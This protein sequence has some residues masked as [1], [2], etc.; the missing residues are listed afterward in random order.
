[1]N[2]IPT[3]AIVLAAIGLGSLVISLTYTAYNAMSY[4][5]WGSQVNGSQGMMGM[6]DNGMMNQGGMMGQ[7]WSQQPQTSYGTTV[8]PDQAKQ[9]AEQYLT[10]LNNP[11]LAIKEIEEWQYNFYIAYYEKDTGLG[12]FQMLIWTQT[13]A[14]GMMGGGMGMGGM[15]GSGMMIGVIMPEPGPN[16]MWNTKYSPMNSGM[17]GGMM[18]G[19]NQAS[20]PMTVSREQALQIAQAWLDSN[21]SGAKVEGD[22]TPFYGYFHM[23]FTLNGRTAGMLDVDGYNGQVW[24]HTWH[25][26]FVQD[27]KID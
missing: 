8:T 12:A 4:P 16:M 13:P 7:Q 2:K 26:A 3:L 11:D 9:I 15:M 21:M 14:S 27:V 23:D 18:G 25:G 22:A 17:M 24:Y 5:N 6:M 1:M 19:P 20:S 10:S